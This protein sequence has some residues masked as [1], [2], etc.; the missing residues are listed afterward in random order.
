M[1]LQPGRLRG[2]R[3]SKGTQQTSAPLVFPGPT[4]GLVTA[5]D[6]AS[7][8]SGAATVL[9]NW[10]PTLTGARV[11][12]GCTK[13]GLAA[14]GGP[15][16]S[17]F[18][19]IYGPIEQ[20]FMATE[21]AIYDMS[22]P[23]L[24]P[25]MTAAIVSGLTSGEWCT[26][27]HTNAGTSYLVCL[28]GTDARRIY[29]G[30][31]WSTTPALTFPDATTSA[32]LNF[33]W[34]FKNREFFLKNGSLDAYYL[35]DLYNIGGETSVFPLGGVMKDGGSLLSGFSWSVESGDGPNEYCVFLSTEGEVAVYAGSNPG[36]ANDFSLVGVYKIARPL[37]KNAWIKSG[38]DVLIATVDGLTPLS[39]AFQR[40]RQQLTLVSAS[41]Q[42]ADLWKA[43][44]AA[45]GSG[46]T[47]TLWPEQNLV[48]VCFPDN[49]AVP[50]TTFVFNTQTGK[51]AIITNWQANCYATHQKSLFF[52]SSDGL[53]WHGDFSG[54]DDGMAFRAVYLSHFNPGQ[55]FGIE[56]E[57]SF[58]K[59]R[60]KSP[61]KPKALLFARADMDVS[62]PP[63]AVVTL[64]TVGS[65]EW[66]V[67]QWDEAQWDAESPVL[68]YFEAR[69][70]V[71][72]SG[73]ALALGCVIVSGGTVALNVEMDIGTLL[74][75]PGEA[76]G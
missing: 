14:D 59:M 61:E 16:I 26:F 1:K 21:T 66:D 65:S 31:T 74:I 38:G 40:D 36:N 54:S 33:G 30:L 20:L 47:L 76:G 60:F 70:N 7:Q 29:N 68:T 44:A 18:R 11:R 28:N 12:G 13:W 73:E 45:T 35:N 67:A 9:E 17:A 50:D 8:T 63:Y 64:N 42:I 25:D 43:A 49:P 2:S 69:Q 34:V 39:Q 19:Y 37:G 23:A 53:A 10:L 58:G 15:I 3:G 57:A 41:R 22:A 48:F 46:W 51:W 75:G 56:K 4:L 27:Q 32:D 71:R 55:G 62:I 52:G 24:P 6:I 72:A 5:A